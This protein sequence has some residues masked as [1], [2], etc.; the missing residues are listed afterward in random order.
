MNTAHGKRSPSQTAHNSTF[1]L[2][3]VAAACAVLIFGAAGTAS[4][5]QATAPSAD[6]QVTPSVITVTGIRRGIEDAISSKKNSDMIVETI[7]AEDLGKLPD[8]SIADALSTL[9]GV[10][11]QIIGGRSAT[12]NIRGLSGDFVNTLFNGREQASVGDNRAVMFDQYPAE[13]ISSAAVYKTPDAELIGQGLAATVDLHT[14]LPLDFPSRVMQFK[15]MGEKASFGELNPEVNNKGDRLSASYIDQFANRTIGVAIGWAHL[16]SPIED[17][18]QHSW[19]IGNGPTQAP[20]FPTAQS[21]QGAEWWSNSSASVRDGLIGVV[22]W[23]PSRD[24]SSVVDTYYSRSSENDY[25]RG[26]QTAT[27]YGNVTNGTIN[28]SNFLSGGNNLGLGGPGAY[29]SA[30]VVRNDFNTEADRIFSIGWKNTFKVDK[31]TL[32]ADLSGS[33]ASSKQQILETYSGAFTPVTGNFAA[34]PYSG[35]RLSNSSFNFANPTAVKLGDPGGWGQDGY[36]KFPAVTDKVKELRLSAKRELEDGIFSSVVGGFNYT[37]REKTRVA[38]E[39]F[40]DFA[41][42]AYSKANTMAIPQNLVVG[43][44]NLPNGPSITGVNTLGLLDAGLYTLI[45]NA[46]NAD[47]YAKN[48]EVDEKIATGYAQLNIDTEIA[49]IPV[50]GNIGLQMVHSNQ[51]TSAIESNG[52]GTGIS[53]SGGASYTNW[54]PSLNLVASLPNDQ[55]LRFGLAQELQRPRFD[56]MNAS[57]EATLS[58]ATRLWSSTAGNPN[59]RPTLANAVDFSFEK[60]FGKKGYIAV[61]PYY[62]Y[63]KT[64]IYQEAENFNFAGVPTGGVTPLSNIGTAT[65]YVNGNGGS[66]KG[67]ELTVSLPFDLIT[68]KLE[69]F[70]VEA[71]ASRG[72]SSI[73]T[74]INGTTSESALP[75]F[76]SSVANMVWYYENNGFSVRYRE[77]YRSAYLGEVQGFGANLAYSDFLGVHTGSLQV[78]YEFKD[79]PMKGLTGLFQVLNI[80]NPTITQLLGANQG[81]A[82]TDVYGRTFLLGLNY[83]M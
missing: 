10:A 39:Y 78:S 58:S 18:Q 11:A 40:V 74:N 25:N 56:D 60:Y 9:P 80:N 31:W 15:A 43:A 38:P 50:R 46:G 82:Q 54:L 21:I 51:S 45:N 7:S 6:A 62:K 47:V 22:Q 16:D 20:G 1:K 36:D 83:K 81:M 27:Y 28:N 49:K 33:N 29:G 14:L 17:Q 69:G 71:N 76:S 44:I 77:S 66:E 59:L 19:G 73:Q 13:L 37:S 70:G 55:Q 79:G 3:P 42:Q 72:S 67:I 52:A 2:S 68:P 41:G 8:D 23:K 24:F 75:G 65:E 5:Q 48:W 57:N 32:V 53:D 26:L 4:A 64:Y 61:A 30:P 12:L 63:L 35:M 34:D